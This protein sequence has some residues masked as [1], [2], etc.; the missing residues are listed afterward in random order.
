MIVGIDLGTTN[1]L[2]AV[3]KDGAPVLIPN[4]LGAMLTPSC[5]GL[6]ETGELLVGQA[7]KDRLQTHPQLTV[8]NF[9]RYMGAAREIS[10]GKR[11]FRPEEISSFVLR[12]LK[13]DAEAFLGH[14]V[15][16]AIISVPAYFSD[17]Q[18]KATRAAGQLAGLRV[19]RLV[20]EPT[21]AALAYGVR[22]AGSERKFLVFDLGGGTFDVSILEIFD[23]VMEVRASA[24]DNFLGGEDFLE[25]LVE[26]IMASIA[27][28]TSFKPDDFSPGDRQRLRD[29]AEKLKRTLSTADS[30]ALSFRL[31]DTEIAYRIDEDRFMALC[32]PLLQRLRLPVERALR[33]ARIRAADLY[34]IVLA[35]GATRMPVVRKLVTRMF[36]RFPATALNPD[37]VVALGVAVQAGLEMDD[38]ALDEMVMTDVCPYTLGIN[39][40]EG[41]GHNGMVSGFYLPI[42]ERNTVVPASRSRDV[43]TVR[44]GQTKVAIEVF[45]GEARLVKDNIP[46]G[47]FEIAVQP[48]MPAG[49]AG[50]SVRF[51]YD[52]NGLL[53]VE[54]TAH[55]TEA[56]KSIV[57]QEHAGVLSGEEIQ[58]RLAA[59]SSLKLHPREDAR[60]AAI[61]A[62]ANRLFE[63]TL[64][65]A[66]L[67]ISKAMAQFEA[68]LERQDPREIATTREQFQAWLD[69]FENHPLLDA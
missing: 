7:A 22:D 4:A 46:L 35:G 64:G 23:G 16:E 44:D 60:N 39:I 42:I 31:R 56:K 68:V 36:G 25:V 57:I 26:D 15:E 32:E 66:R 20:N 67:V 41:S 2:V 40:V 38:A 51:T 50:V 21:A 1:S 47:K 28:H 11:K 19:E 29:A 18:R 34:E 53:E 63:E 69:R 65:E 8:A 62:R 24:G 59:L 12:S 45:Q 49:A 55:G 27:A 58:Q 10:L 61:M 14:P 54:A 13:A 5:V 6:S 17:A 37:E 52:V 9:K 43:F 30:A 3:W 33:D 48:G